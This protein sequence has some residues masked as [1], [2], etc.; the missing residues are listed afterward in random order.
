MPTK[1]EL[2]QL[3]GDN[4]IPDVCLQDE[5]EDFRKTSRPQT[6]RQTSANFSRSC[7]RT[8]CRKSTAFNRFL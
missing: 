7:G 1:M 4:D 5:A 6:P 2:L 8:N 3:H